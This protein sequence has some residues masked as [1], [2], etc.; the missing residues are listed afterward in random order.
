LET[1]RQVAP[2]IVSTRIRVQWASIL[3]GGVAFVLL[4]MPVAH[5]VPRLEITSKV[6]DQFR[7][8][9]GWPDLARS[10]ANVY[11]SLSAQEREHTDSHRNYEKQAL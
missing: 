2:D 3:V 9:I 5:R 1:A 4:V 10:V 11:S 8:E 6:H 7:E